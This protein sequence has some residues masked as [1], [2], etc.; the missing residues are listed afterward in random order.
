MAPVLDEAARRGLRTHGEAISHPERRAL[1]SMVKGEAIELTDAGVMV[2]AEGSILVLASDGLDTLSDAE[3]V[4]QLERSR[5]D[6]QRAVA[7]L[8]AAAAARSRPEQDNISVVVLSHPARVPLE[9]QPRRVRSRR[10]S[11]NW[12]SPRTLGLAALILLLT[13]VAVIVL[14]GA[15]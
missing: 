2:L 15:D 5:G 12:R 6:P 3:I 9:R 4:R 8:L 11:I 7:E 10:R 14:L 13:V 1:R